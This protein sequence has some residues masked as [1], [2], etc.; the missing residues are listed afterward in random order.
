[1][2][3]S[4]KDWQN[5]IDR[6][7]KINEKAAEKVA[8]FMATHDCS[9]PEGIKLLIDYANAVAT[10]YGEGAAELTCQMYDAIADASGAFVPAAE[11]AATATY[12]E[13]AKTIYGTLASTKDPAAVGAAVGRSVKLASVD[14]L[15]QNTL[16]DGAEWAWIPQGDTCPFCL[17]L[18]SNGWRRASKKAIKNGHADHI[19]NNCDCT[20]CVR[21]DHETTVEGYDPD[22]LYDQYINAGDTSNER[23]NAL[24]RQHYAANRDYIRAQQNAA[25]A[26]RV[27]AKMKEANPMLEPLS[28]SYISHNDELYENVQNVK[29]IKG[30]EDF[31]VHGIPEESLVEYETN[32]GMWVKYNAK[33]IADMIR[34]EPSYG[35]GKIRLLSCGAGSS[36][37]NF[38]QELANEL[39]VEV[40]APTE[41]LWVAPNGEMFISDNEILADMWYNKGDI[42]Y[43]FQPTG[44]WRPFTPKPK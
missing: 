4:K 14:T 17:M 5:Y 19:H 10:K 41:T 42:D 29:P 22:A 3:I 30:Y 9:T 32:N 23:I 40:L 6:L 20:Y 2:K 35:G 21:F 39:G 24:R 31:A 28:R 38:A 44:R 16:R 37:S 34:E 12:G 7:R 36:R 43:S 13:I 18:A 26:R 1:M 25:Y 33:D 15:M 11:P 8:N 27:T